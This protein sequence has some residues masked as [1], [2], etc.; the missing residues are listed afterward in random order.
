MS[1]SLDEPVV[2]R[3]Y[4]GAFL[5]MVVVALLAAIGGL[6]WS[7]TLS[8]RLTKS[9]TA[10]TAAQA[11]NEKLSAALDQTNAELKV[12]TQ[13]LGKSLGMTQKQ[14]E[15]RAADL[16]R[17]QQASSR[18]LESEQKAASEAANAAKLVQLSALDPKTWPGENSLWMREGMQAAVEGIPLKLTY[19]S[20]YPFRLMPGAP[21]VEGEGINT[22]FSLGKGGLST[23]WGTSVMP[24]RQ[25]DMRG[26]PVSADELAPHYARVLDFMPVAQVR[27]ALE[28]AFPTFKPTETMPLSAQATA[29]L[30]R[31]EQNQA[32]LRKQ[33]I[34]FGHSRLAINS[35]GRDAHGTGAAQ[36]ACTRCALCMYGCPY[37]L[38]YSTGQTVDAMRSDPN[39]TYAPGHVVQR[40]EEAGD[41]VRVHS[42]T[43][44]GNAEVLAG[45]RAYVGAG[46][47][48]TAAI[49][50]RSLDAYNQRITF[51]E[52]HYFLL[53]MLRFRG[54]RNFQRG[55]AHTLA[56]LFLEVLDESISPSTTHLQLYTYNDLFEAPIAAKLGPLSKVF[57]WQAFLSRLML[58]Q[59]FMHSDD[60]PHT[61]AVLE[62][63]GNGDALQLSAT[64]FPHTT[65]ILKKLVARLT[66]VRSLTGMVPLSPLMREGEPGRSFHSGGSF[67][68]SR[69]PTGFETDLLGRPAGLKRVHVVDASALP[70][71]P[72]TTITFTIMANAHR[73]G[74]LVGQGEA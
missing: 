26:W 36:G 54:I 37:G 56:Q 27:D 20:D 41:E 62:R 2:E 66:K 29:L 40:L 64:I 15:T 47:L 23:V 39:F 73:I 18:K 49:L 4:S 38:L 55:D 67:P 70:S 45:T 71:I 69:T 57:P 33:G 16:V 58:I 48:P 34:T 52:S 63:R 10:L 50:L 28:E 6:V 35:T 74:T 30:A 17:Q 42:I 7:Y 3:N 1:D 24:F 14:L 21:V 25:A 68:M 11:Q 59:G 65:Q 72:G 31:M 32:A 19:A 12:E 60:S 51:C 61:H 53:P 5:A 22:K 43:N 44:A 8:T 46:V 9:E 13:E